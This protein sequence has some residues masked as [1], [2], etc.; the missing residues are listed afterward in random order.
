MAEELQWRSSPA[1]MA[2]HLTSTEMSA[3]RGDEE[4]D[5][6]WDNL[7]AATSYQVYPHTKLLAEKFVDAAFGRSRNVIVEMGPRYGKSLL[8]SQWAPVWYLE[9][10]PSSRVILASYGHDLALHNARACRNIMRAYSDRL[11]TQ[12]SKDATAADQWNTVEGGGLKAAGV[13]GALTG[14]GASLLVVDDPLKDWEEA[15]SANQREKVWSWF[16]SV[17]LTRRHRGAST[18]IIATRWHRDD[19]SGRLI[20][21]D[22]ERVRKGHPPIWEVIRLPTIADGEARGNPDPLGR[23]DGE[24]LCPDLFPAEEVLEQREMLGNLIFGAM[25]QQDPT[26][27]EG[28]IILREWWRRFDGRPQPETL[29]GWTISADLSFKGNANSDAVVIQVWARDATDHYLLDQDRGRYSYTDTKAAIQRMYARWPQVTRV[30][31]E[32]A[33]NGPAVISELGQSIPGMIGIKPLGSKLSRVNAITPLIR[34]GHVHIPSDDLA[35]WSIGFVDEC[36]AFTG[37]KDGI[38]DQVD[39]MSQYLNQSAG[40]PLATTASRYRYSATVR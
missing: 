19:L 31:V 13:G 9:L 16:R 11:T 21:E 26:D 40:G 30:L 29:Y 28:T 6:D 3:R 23:E 33:A 10:F 5:D 27:P 39:A 4:P 2:A 35:P 1:R 18:I 34:T 17:L 24:V 20:T 37:E 14:F 8:F 22:R 12:L 36:A 25:H 7:A 32:D 38:D 15:Q